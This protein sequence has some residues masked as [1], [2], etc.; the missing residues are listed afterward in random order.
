MYKTS[1]EVLINLRE[2]KTSLPSV[3][4]QMHRYFQKKDIEKWIMFAR[5]KTLY[6]MEDDTID[7]G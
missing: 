5:A 7:K 6:L 3:T 4:K 1:E 2:G